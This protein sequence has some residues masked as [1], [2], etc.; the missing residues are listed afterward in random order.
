M[1]FEEA[2][3]RIK[4]E[5]PC[6]NFLE[7]SPDRQRDM[8]CCPSCHSGYGGSGSTGALRYYARGTAGTKCVSN[9]RC[10]C[11]SCGKTFDVLDVYKLANNCD[12]ATAFKDLCA[13]QGI[14]VESEFQR[15]RST[16]QEDFA[17]LQEK[18]V[19]APEMPAERVDA[20][21]GKDTGKPAES[22][23]SAA[24]ADYRPYYLFCR[25]LLPQAPEAV[26]YLKQRGISV[27][28]ARAVSIGF[29]PK[30]DPATAPG[31]MG[32]EYRRHP[33]PR[34]IVPT[35]PAHYV[36]RSIDTN[37]DKRY[38]KMNPNKDLGGGEPGVFNLRALRTGGDAV[39][40]TEGAF[41]SLS[42]LEAGMNAI[43]LNSTGNRRILL[44]YLE[45]KKLPQGTTL[46]LALDN[47]GAGTSAQADIEAACRRLSIPFV[48]WHNSTGKDPNEFLTL[49]RKGFMDAVAKV[50]MQTAP[51]PD[52]LGQYFEDFMS[53]DLEAYKGTI[54]TGFPVLDKLSGGLHP[55]LYVLGAVSSL[56]KTTFALQLADSVAARG[57]DV[58]FFSL[59]Q[60]RLELASKILARRTAEADLTT[61]VT[62]LSIRRG[63][64]PRQVTDAKND[65]LRDG[66]GDKLSIIESNFDLT[67]EHLQDY[68]T[69]Y[70]KKNPES[71]PLVILDYLQ[72]VTPSDPRKSTK[73]A[74]DATTT[75]LK[76]VSRDL[77][78][79]VLVISSLN[80]ASYSDPISFESFKESGIIE[81]SADVVWG[82]QLSCMSDPSWEKKNQADKRESVKSAKAETPRK[83]S[84][85]CLKNRFGPS[86]YSADFEYF[87]ANDL[88]RELPQTA[89]FKPPVKIGKR[90]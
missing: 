52:A 12:F 1:T 19:K 8:Y 77:S 32:T 62:S 26:A 30:A 27:E 16:P 89:E 85:V 88:F 49:D 43:A 11:Y 51:R 21:Q 60:S 63:Y 36:A 4:E 24:Q 45:K 22:P 74:I 50:K 90:V 9:N 71:R 57:T 68:L 23:Q 72:I 28:T 55:G 25:D 81:Y 86:S 69:N 82:L 37:T 6:T 48:L 67:P 29:D 78:L 31:A 79:T 34:I 38:L 44:S 7:R 54:S 20:P 17:D 64:I 13:M 84:L 75:A 40:V 15:R 14:T 10:H 33:A 70:L 76:R 80:R 58:L 18:P 35:T 2:L 65:F 66:A 56:G 53:A 47:D 87:P 61:A 3:S 39:A 73:D 42:F 46:V 83:V 59:E 41:D 5:V